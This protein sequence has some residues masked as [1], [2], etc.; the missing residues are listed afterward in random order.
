M[1]FN[2]FSL[3]I[4]IVQIIILFIGVQGTRI[5][6]GED[7]WMGDFF[8]KWSILYNATEKLRKGLN[9]V[10]TQSELK[11][12]SEEFSSLLDIIK[13]NHMSWPYGDSVESIFFEEVCFVG[14]RKDTLIVEDLEKL[15]QTVRFGIKIREA[16]RLRQELLGEFSVLRYWVKNY[17]TDWHI[18]RGLKL[19]QIYFILQVILIL[20]ISFRK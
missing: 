17:I 18:K 20:I 1:N 9:G 13:V 12:D 2:W 7:R 8:K 3:I 11:K 10:G 16:E 14:T 4:A 19:I 15:R 5:A 6:A